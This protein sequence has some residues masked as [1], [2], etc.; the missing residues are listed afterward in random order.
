M[1]LTVLAAP[2]PNDSSGCAPTRAELVPER[3]S[4]NVRRAAPNRVANV[5]VGDRGGLRPSG[6][7]IEPLCGHRHPIMLDHR[8]AGNG[9]ERADA[10]WV[11]GS[12]PTHNDGRSPSG[13]TSDSAPTVGMTCS[14]PAQPVREVIA[15]GSMRVNVPWKDPD[16]GRPPGSSRTGFALV[17]TLSDRA[18]GEARGGDL[19]ERRT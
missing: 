10:G 12:R 4:Q 3:A 1:P 13:P 14:V 16:M 5:P 8:D 17:T 18:V 2:R 19:D 6:L 7:A 9:P 11:T 15:T